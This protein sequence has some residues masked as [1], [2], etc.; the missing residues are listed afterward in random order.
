MIM[1]YYRLGKYEDARRSME[2]ML[3]FARRFRMDNNLTD[4]GND[5]Y[6][7]KLPINITYDAFGVPAALIRGLFE[8][9]YTA[10]GLKLLPHIPP[11]ISELQQLDPIRFGNKKL[12]LSTVGSG[13]ITSV[14]VN[15]KLWRTF[16]SSSV[17]L[18]YADTPD[19]ARIVI[20]LGGSSEIRNTVYVSSGSPLDTEDPSPEWKA[21]EAR[22][23]KVGSFY[24]SLHRLGWGDC[25]EAAHARLVLAAVDAAHEHRKLLAAGKLPPLPQASEAAADK[26][27]L[28]TATKLYDGLAAVVKNYEKSS[29]E[30]ARKIFALWSE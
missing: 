28:D 23:A 26:S 29:D 27:Y 17:F 6:Q 4:F 22:T 24:A 16:D 30:R 19:E 8:Y 7:P 3:T 15:G 14:R 11:G 18:P 9:L 12:Y 25:Y 5:V 13:P 21:L 2:K 1:A 10:E 20:G